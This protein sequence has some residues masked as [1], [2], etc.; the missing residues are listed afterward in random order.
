MC[1]LSG[2]E[3]LIYTI[4]MEQQEQESTESKTVVFKLNYER[5]QVLG[6]YVTCTS[7]SGKDYVPVAVLTSTGF[8]LMHFIGDAEV[9]SHSPC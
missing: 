7:S 4:I 5:L 2:S 9:V 1:S 6:F 8:R 3:S